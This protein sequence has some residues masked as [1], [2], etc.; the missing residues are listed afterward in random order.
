[1][2]RECKPCFP[3]V[4]TD[5]A[6]ALKR[7]EEAMRQEWEY[8]G[9]YD[10]DGRALDKSPYETHKLI[11]EACRGDGWGEWELTKHSIELLLEA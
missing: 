8:H 11:A 3:E 10:A 1:M 2:P 4:F 7:F 9:P 5:E 6:S